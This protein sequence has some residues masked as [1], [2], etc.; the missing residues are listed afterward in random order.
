MSQLSVDAVDKQSGSTLTLGGAGTTVDIPSGA[1]LDVTG[2]NISG[3]TTGKVLQV[4]KGASSTLFSTTSSSNVNTNVSVTITPSSTSSIILVSYNAYWYRSGSGSGD[5]GLNSRDVQRDGSVIISP[6]YGS[7][8]RSTE[9]D[10]GILYDAPATTSA[11][12]YVFRVA[13]AS[14]Y[15]INVIAGSYMV[16]MEVGP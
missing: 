16:A 7:T 11:V 4:V 13:R 3:L 10:S 15:T 8:T 6:A 14:T 9:T 1:T 5:A 12:N 2:A